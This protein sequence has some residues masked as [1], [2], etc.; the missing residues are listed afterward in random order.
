M[1]RRASRRSATRSAV[2][3]RAAGC[4]VAIEPL[5]GC[6]PLL[7]ARLRLGEGASVLILGHSDTVWPVGTVGDLAVPRRRRLAVGPGVGDMKCCLA[8]AVHAMAALGRARPRGSRRGAA[9]G[10]AGRGARQHRLP[11]AHRGG[12]ARGRPPASS[13]RPPVR[14][15]VSS[16]AAA[17]SERC[18]SWRRGSGRHVTD[19]GERASA[20]APLAALVGPIEAPGARRAA[21]PWPRSDA[22]S[23]AR[24]RQVVP[25]HGRAAG[26]PARDARSACAEQLADRVRALVAAAPRRPRR[27]AHGRGRR[28]ATGLAAR[29]GVARSVRA[30]RGRRRR[31]RELACTRCAS[32]A[33]RTRR[34]RGRRGC[35]RWTASGP[36]CHDSCSRSERVEIASIPIWGAI[37][38]CVAASAAR[39]HRP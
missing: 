26:R 19:P 25:E 15:A 22:S 10:R 24:A 33:D 32:A 9:S 27:D 16:R 5:A 29:R 7:D 18:G 11:A 20:L 21:M 37:L 35:P 13:S 17:R 28:H 38:A 36:I 4:E 14:A 6:G 34:S 2:Q 1:P 39:R 30:G 23:P 12:G 3:P 31:A 8:T